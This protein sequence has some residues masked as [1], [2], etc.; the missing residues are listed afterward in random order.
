MNTLAV[1]CLRFSLW[2]SEKKFTWDKPLGLGT[3]WPGT[4]NIGEKGK[5]FGTLKPECLIQGDRLIRCRLIL[6]IVGSSQ[7]HTLSENDKVLVWSSEI[8]LLIWNLKK[9]KNQTN[10]TWFRRQW[11]VAS[12]YKQKRVYNKKII[13]LKHCHC[14]K[15]NFENYYKRKWPKW[16]GIMS[17]WV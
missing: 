3:E 10:K 4:L 13:N 16:V 17:S 9:Q 7:P 12:S 15:P 11:L 14:L 5:N 2:C 8:L 1:H 6:R